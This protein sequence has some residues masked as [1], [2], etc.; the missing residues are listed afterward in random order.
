MDNHHCPVHDNQLRGMKKNFN[1]CIQI[2]FRSHLWFSAMKTWLLTLLIKLCKSPLP[3]QTLLSFFGWFQSSA[4]VWTSLHSQHLYFK[5]HSGSKARIMCHLLTHF[6]H[7][8]SLPKK[9]INFFSP[10]QPEHWIKKLIKSKRAMSRSFLYASIQSSTTDWERK[11]KKDL[12][13][14]N[15]YNHQ[16]QWTWI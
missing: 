15:C 6:S 14:L 5:S 1:K 7:L 11:R 10:L 4:F 16:K 3:H 2:D 8:N 13:H 12:Y 9:K